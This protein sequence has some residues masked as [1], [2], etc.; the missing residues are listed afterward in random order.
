MAKKGIIE[1]IFSKAKFADDPMLYRVFY[2][3]FDRIRELT[4]LEF[5][6][7]S[8]FFEAIPVTRIQMIKKNN[9]TLFRK[10]V[11]GLS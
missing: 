2:R 11:H 10:Y 6:N 7:E 9:K 3:D 1:E 5:L 8:N 4:L